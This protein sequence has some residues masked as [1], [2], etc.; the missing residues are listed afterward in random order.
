MKVEKLGKGE[1]EHAILYCVH[2]SEPCG[3]YAVEKLKNQDL[4]FEKP[5]KLVLANEKAFD[6]G[7]RF[8][9]KDLNRCFPGD[10]KSEVHE[11]NLAYRITEELDGLKVLDLHSTYSH[12]EPFAITP[13]L[14]SRR[15]EVAISSG[16]N[17]VVAI[18]EIV[19]NY[20]ENVD[21]T[22]V[23]CGHTGTDQAIR[24]AFKILKNFLTSEGVVKEGFKTENN[25][26]DFYEIY[27]RVEGTG[28]IFLKENFEEVKK[29]EKFAE[30]I[31]GEAKTAEN[32]FY[33]VLMSTNG[34]EDIIGFKARKSG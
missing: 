27:E 17:N 30:K 1:P 22:A 33:P 15:K 24:N 18:G 5:I 10:K 13:V 2:G 29:N 9:E 34:Y 28:Y 31:N 16:V 21:R 32:S 4:D 25:N 26:T 23:E 3:H 14:N 12:S 8:V 6:Q 19:D 20:M 7:E 11:E